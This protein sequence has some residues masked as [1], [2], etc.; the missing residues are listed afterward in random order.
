[1]RIEKLSLRFLHSSTLSKSQTA[2]LHVDDTL[3]P[4]S[5]VIT[6]TVQLESIW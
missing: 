2:Y 6:V 5:L 1:M 3:N 4:N